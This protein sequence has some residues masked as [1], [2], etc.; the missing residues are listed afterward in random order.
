MGLVERSVR[1]A[2]RPRRGPPRAPRRSVAVC[3]ALRL[4]APLCRCV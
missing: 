1:R 3:H 2:P 4:R